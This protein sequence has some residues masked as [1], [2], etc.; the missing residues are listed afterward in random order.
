LNALAFLL[1]LSK[2]LD[3]ELNALL[4]LSSTEIRLTT[5]WTISAIEEPHHRPD[6]AHVS[7]L[8][9]LAKHN[10]VPLD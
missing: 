2:P 9:N 1:L 8:V 6:S 4:V 3:M 10:H 5:S 7:G